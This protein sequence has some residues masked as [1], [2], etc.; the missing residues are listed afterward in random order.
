MA[1]IVLITVIAKPPTL[2]KSIDFQNGINLSPFCTFV[3]GLRPKQ[4]SY[5]SVSISVKVFEF[6]GIAGKY[7]DTSSANA[8]T[9]V[10]ASVTVSYSPT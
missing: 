9:E 5:S 7:V 2:K 4:R 10:G 8:V 3:L 1:K 6:V